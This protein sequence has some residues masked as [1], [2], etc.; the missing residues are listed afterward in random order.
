MYVRYVIYASTINTI[1]KICALD[2]R[3][4]FFQYII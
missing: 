1:R 2:L 3:R 4:E